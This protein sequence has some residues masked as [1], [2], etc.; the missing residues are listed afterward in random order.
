MY[1]T[2]F[3]DVNLARRMENLDAV[4]GAEYARTH[5]LLFPQSDAT[6]IAVAGGRAT[7]AGIESPITQAF[8]LGMH[9]KVTAIEIDELEE[10]YRSRRAPVN[11]EVCPL[12][13]ASLVELLAARGYKPIEFSNVLVRALLLDETNASEAGQRDVHARLATPNEAEAWAQA[14]ARG[15]METSDVPPPM[16]DL[17]TTIFHTSG[18]HCFV[19]EQDGVIIGGGSMNI[20]DGIAALAGAS[21]LPAYRKRGAQGALLDYRLQFAMKHDCELATVATLPGSASQRNAERN[22]FRVAYTRTK[23]LR[24]WAS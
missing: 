21:M 12:A 14:A 7:F 9:G 23:W 24:Q 10:F 6:S 19:A 3:A 4:G 18:T 11:I 2:L 5:A 20:R 22:G 15:L 1:T 17:F 16:R 13:D 8:A